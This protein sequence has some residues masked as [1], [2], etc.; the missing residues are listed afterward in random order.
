MKKCTKCLIDKELSEFNK[1]NKTKDGR[2]ERCRYCQNSDSKKY[3]QDN[4]DY[5]EKFKRDWNSNNP[6][7]MKEYYQDNKEK[8]KEYNKGYYLNNKE[9]ILNNNSRY[10]FLNKES[11]IKRLSIYY[12]NNRELKLEYNKKYMRLKYKNYP[13][14]FAHRNILKRHLKYTNVAKS[15]RTTELLGYSPTDLKLHIESLFIDN[16]T[17]DNYGEW[18][19]DHIKP[20]SKFEKTDDT[21]IVNSLENLRPLWAI[22]NLKKSNK[23]D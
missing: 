14:L 16:M 9:I 18:H 6:N 20:I 19:I 17:W 13:Y 12:Y 8:I 4:K 15:S 22:D 3:Y 1:S 23:Y 2:R 11:V 7:Y 21:S 10:Y 5:F